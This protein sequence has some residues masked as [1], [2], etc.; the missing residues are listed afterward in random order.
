MLVVQLL[1]WNNGIVLSIHFYYG[2]SVIVQQ[3]VGQLQMTN[4]YSYEN[5]KHYAAALSNYFFDFRLLTLELLNHPQ[6]LTHFNKRCN[7]GI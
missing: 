4:Y 5:S 7:S 3:L 2:Q 1:Y 6:F